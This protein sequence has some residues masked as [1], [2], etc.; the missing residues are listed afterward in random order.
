MMSFMR[1]YSIIQGFSVVNI[2]TAQIMYVIVGDL[3][4][5]LNQRENQGSTQRRSVG[6]G[7]DMSP[8]P[9]SLDFDSSCYWRAKV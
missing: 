6:G 3:N 1:L 9:P 2:M 7:R 5:I 4:C 8:P